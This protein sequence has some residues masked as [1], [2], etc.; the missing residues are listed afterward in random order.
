MS[1]MNRSISIYLLYSIVFYSIYRL[2][3]K[4]KVVNYS[5]DVMVVMVKTTKNCVISANTLNTMNRTA[6]QSSAP[7]PEEV[8]KYGHRV[9]FERQTRRLRG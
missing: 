1:V 5:L 4:I 9:V 2:H 8:E 6:A 7:K 3:F